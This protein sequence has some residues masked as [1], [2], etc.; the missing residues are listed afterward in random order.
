MIMQLYF[1]F[2]FQKIDSD[3]INKKLEIHLS[4]N[5]DHE[6]LTEI[7]AYPQLKEKDRLELTELLIG[8]VDGNCSKRI[9]EYLLNHTE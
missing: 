9:T 4:G 8:K 3:M 2:F 6:V 1:F 5:I 7:I